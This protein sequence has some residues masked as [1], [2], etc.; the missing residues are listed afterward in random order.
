MI[1]TKCDYAAGST[2]SI[3][4]QGILNIVWFVP[5]AI[6]ANDISVNCGCI[7]KIG[8]AVFFVKGTIFCALIERF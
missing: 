6:S 4:K 3:R 2:G 1:V 7:R 8:S 5:K